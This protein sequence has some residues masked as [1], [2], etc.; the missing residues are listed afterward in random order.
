MNNL[1]RKIGSW[2]KK[3]E[4]AGAT[5]VLVLVAAVFLWPA[6]GREGYYAPVDTIIKMEP[7]VNGARPHNYLLTDVVQQFLPWFKLSKS[8]IHQ[9]WLP[10][11][12]VYSGGGLPLLANMQ[13]AIF[14]PLT[15]LAYLLPLKLALFLISFFKLFFVGLFAF[16]Y[17]R[18]I[19]SSW[20]VAMLGATAFLSS[21]FMVNWL[22]W[23]HTNV[24]FAL[25]AGLYLIE[26]WITEKLPPPNLPL[27]KGEGNLLWFGLIL[28]LAVFGGHPETFF[29]VVLVLVIYGAVRIFQE[30]KFVKQSFFKFFVALIVG[31]LLSAPAWLP[32][33]EYLQQSAMLVARNS[34]AGNGFYIQKLF[35]VANWMPD[36]FGNPAVNGW[37]FNPKAN[38][39]ELT[40]GY[41]GIFLVFAC[42][43]GVLWQ[44]RDRYVRLF[45][46]IGA[47]CL[48]V[49]YKAPLIF[50][51]V[52]SLPGF[53]SGTN[54]RLMLIV[55]WCVVVIGCRGLQL[56]VD[57]KKIKNR[58]LVIGGG[59]LAAGG[60]LFALAYGWIKDLASA[61]W[62]SISGWMLGSFAAFTLAVVF[63]WL[64]LRKIKNSKILGLAFL[65]VLA[66][67]TLHGSIYNATT[68]SKIFY[69]K[70]AG[71]E[72]LSQAFKAEHGR[73]LPLGNVLPP[74]L[75]TWYGFNQVNEYDAMGL[76]SWQELK[77]RIGDFKSDWEKLNGPI[78]WQAAKFIGASYVAAPV[79]WA[80]DLKTESKNEAK[81]VY[82]DKQMVIL[83]QSAMP[84]VYLVKA[85][86]LVSQEEAM[87]KVLNKKYEDI[88][89]IKVVNF[90]ENGSKNIAYKADEPAVM[91]LNENYYAG[92]VAR[93]D[94]EKLP[95]ISWQGLKAVAVPEGENVLTLRY[96]PMSLKIGFGLFGL[97]ALVW[98]GWC[99][100]IKKYDN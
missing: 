60:F 25:P 32:F 100:K 81:E 72:Y 66:E 23:P 96:E 1:I 47:F 14:F 40:M 11:W 89:Q 83:K 12:N 24:V 33:L 29:Y 94:S 71:V 6:I 26:K 30:A 55:A 51:L 98:L 34:Q 91:I 43:Y 79:S 4:V 88:F 68:S 48:A 7:F 3:H 92:W 10:L 42:A 63:T 35:F 44:W 67:T 80:D 64:I 39:N 65:L 21:G 19:K 5:V 22:M 31:A 41:V 85:D 9:G 69:P 8:L 86:D 59:L 70:N 75:G 57:D 97:G 95:I 16:L 50:S 53:K 61:K 37:W 76:E 20:G 73:V 78:S 56:M 28:M 15:W 93:I 90:Y 62:A 77:T 27:L 84:M 52:V 58:L 45:A 17:L 13:S 99:L 74:N 2:V 54:H 18:Q 38:C 49:A 46:W 82:R 36:I 87:D